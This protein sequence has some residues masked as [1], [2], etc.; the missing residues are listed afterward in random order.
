MKTV[1]WI[2]GAWSCF[3]F[4]MGAQG[5]NLRTAEE[6]A[7]IPRRQ[8]RFLPRELVEDC[9]INCFCQDGE[10]EGT[11]YCDCDCSACNVG[12]TLQD[13]DY[14]GVD[15]YDQ[16]LASPA[17]NDSTEYYDAHYRD[18]DDY[19]PNVS[20]KKTASS[21]SKGSLRSGSR[22]GEGK[23]SKSKSKGSGSKGKGG[24]G[25][26]QSSSSRSHGK[27]SGSGSGSSYESHHGKGHGSG[28]RS[29]YGSK[30]GTGS[31]SKGVSGSSSGYR[32]YG[33]KGSSG[34][35]VGSGYGI[36][37]YDDDD[38]GSLSA[39]RNSGSR[40]GS[41]GASG[42]R[43]TSKGASGSR[44]DSADLKP[45]PVPLPYDSAS[46]SSGSVSADTVSS[47]SIYDTVD[48]TS[49]STDSESYESTIVEFEVDDGYLE[50]TVGETS[51]S[52]DS[53]SYESTIVEFEVDDGYLEV[54]DDDDYYN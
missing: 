2:L 19:Y 40:S 25:H 37:Y 4:V 28:S 1:Q 27:G 52:T 29:S 8:W 45:I 42:S 18:D 3:L 24:K 44:S 34:S 20:G 21:S 16:F 11:Q 10:N 53:E 50:D 15:H 17:D 49:G 22:S 41:K 31:G 51:G 9:C 43:S 5:R 12:K 7:A 39:S 54:A 13:N 36:N 23:G 35:S 38:Y 48:E 26:Y 30:G 47:I 33:S 14:Q 46:G 32:Y 6:D